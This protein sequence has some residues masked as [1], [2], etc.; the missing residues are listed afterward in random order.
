[1]N[2]KVSLELGKR[3]RFKLTSCNNIIGCLYTPEKYYVKCSSNGVIISNK[4]DHNVYFTAELI[5]IINGGVSL[6]QIPI[7]NLILENI[8][9]E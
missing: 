3:Y 5:G 6:N 9:Y 7:C 2:E 8:I 4:K 1:M